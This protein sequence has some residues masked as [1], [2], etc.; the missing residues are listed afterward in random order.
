MHYVFIDDSVPFDG[1]TSGRRPLG[2]AEKAFASLA[3]AIAGRGHTVTALNRTPYPVIAEAVRYRP[4]D[5][6]QGR[7]LD[8]D[9]V[10]A[11]RQ[12]SLLG[13]VRKA[14][15]RLLWAVA[16]PDYLKAAANDR[17]WESFKPTLLFV[18]AT[19]ARGY[20][21]P[22]SHRLLAPGVRSIFALAPPVLERSPDAPAEPPAPKPP[23]VIVTTHPLHG[24]AWLTEIWRRLIHPQLPE[25]RMAVYSSILAKGVRD[26]AVPEPIQPVL[27]RVRSAAEANV[28]VIDPLG[29]DGMAAAYRDSRIHLYPGH[30][31]DYACWT[32]LESQAAGT[33]AIARPV[34]GTEECVVNGQTGFL[35][36]DATAFGNVAIELLRNEAVH[37]SFSSAAADMSR[38]R[39]WEMAAAELDQIVSEL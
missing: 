27:N 35:V 1:F 19:Q 38:R 36:P 8:A 33:P 39:T 28:V 12:P 29:D 24:L 25:A 7:P 10:V 11:F 30:P 34:G 15:H 3:A 2:G 4:L 5:E 23:H 37:A 21:G 16:Q 17:Y 18:S 22:L 32:L 9:V 6:I 20:D 13:T 14:K 26:E 31:Q